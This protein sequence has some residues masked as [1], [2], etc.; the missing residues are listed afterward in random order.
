MNALAHLIIWL[1]AAA[2]AIGRVI[3]APVA[4]LPGWL[5]ATLIAA[6]TGVLL[7]I[8]FKY[9][10]NQRAIKRVRDDIKAHLLAIKLFKDSPVVTLQAQGRVFRGAFLLMLYAIVPI[11]VMAVPVSLMLSQISLWY[12]ARPLDVGEV[13]L[14]SLKLSGGPEAGMPDV[15][16][17]SC[18]AFEAEIGPVRVP[19]KREVYWSIQAKRAG[20]HQLTFHVGDS[21]FEKELVVGARFQRTSRMRPGW[22]WSDMMLHPWEAPFSPDSPVESITI[23]YPER[24]SWATGADSWVVYWFVV[25][26][27]A[28]ILAKPWLN[29][30]I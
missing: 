30:N 21:S 15:R 18:D 20:R 7:L 9:T 13:A 27:V 28:A 3:L 26:M 19:S 25:S 6:A 11:L 8:V 14:I 24:T 12:Q 16:L 5:S 22:N 17:N 2:N 4:L 23:Q 1:N 29:V 10:S